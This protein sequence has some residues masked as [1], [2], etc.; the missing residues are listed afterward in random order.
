[1]LLGFTIDSTSHTG[2]GRSVEAIVSCV[3]T[4]PRTGKEFGGSISEG[5]SCSVNDS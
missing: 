5:G 3:S 4:A 2:L 1:M